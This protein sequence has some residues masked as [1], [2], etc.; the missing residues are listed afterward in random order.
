MSD[1]DHVL[2]ER[3]GRYGRFLEHAQIT[4]ALKGIV[5]E[6]GGHKLAPD[7]LEA[8]EMICH[9]MG[10][11]LNGDPDYADSWTDISGYSKLVADRLLKVGEWADH[12]PH[13]VGATDVIC[14]GGVRVS[15]GTDHQHTGVGGK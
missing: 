11:I 5:Y 8:L 1:I 14:A 13:L 7:Q 15:G 12:P 9:K 6:Y 4:Q 3:H 2:K 10:R